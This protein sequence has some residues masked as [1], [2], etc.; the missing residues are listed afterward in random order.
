MRAWLAPALCAPLLLAA[1]PARA[2]PQL[3]ELLRKIQSAGQHTRTLQA[4]FVQR[5]RMPMFKSEVVT[6]GRLVFAR[7]DRLRWETLAPDAAVLVLRGEKAE[8]RL[9]GE[10]ARALD[11]KAGSALGSLV[12]QMLVWFGV[13]PAAEL[14]KHHQVTLRGSAAEPQLHLVP[15]DQALRKRVAAIDIWLGMDLAPTRI[16]VSAGEEVTRIEFG[17]VK[18]NGTL[19][20]SLFR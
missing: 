3:D 1:A 5:K 6:K 9:P 8:L 11:L 16:Q 10:P 17:A 14:H 18:R 13:R 2:T 12:D 20:D 7:P 4:S 15:K 19:P